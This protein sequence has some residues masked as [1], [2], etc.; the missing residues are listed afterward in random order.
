MSLADEF[1]RIQFERFLLDVTSKLLSPA[2][3]CCTAANHLLCCV[4]LMSL[5]PGI[6]AAPFEVQ[7]FPHVL[8][9]ET[10][11]NLHVW[12]ATNV[13]IVRQTN[14]KQNSV[15][16]PRLDVV[17]SELYLKCQYTFLC[18]FKVQTVSRVCCSSNSTVTETVEQ[19]KSVTVRVRAERFTK[20]TSQ[21]FLWFAA[22]ALMKH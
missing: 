12:E 22:G 8:S 16:F 9:K 3:S 18:H 11:A 15:W 17:D 4:R 5:C 1:R 21:V 20:R 10:I 6:K 13:Q 19:L 2:Y 7:V 14:Q